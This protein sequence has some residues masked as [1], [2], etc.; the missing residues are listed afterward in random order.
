VSRTLNAPNTNGTV[1]PYYY[2]PFDD[3]L[4]EAVAMHWRLPPRWDGGQIRFYWQESTA[5]AAKTLYFGFGTTAFGDG[6]DQDPHGLAN[7]AAVADG[8]SNDQGH[9]HITPWTAFVDVTNGGLD[10]IITFYIYRDG[11]H[12]S[13]TYAYEIITFYIYRDGDHA[14]DTYAYDA[15]LRGVELEYTTNQATDDE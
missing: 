2:F 14:S 1:L 11:D 3:A 9:L 13:D 12:A 5:E 10:K 15:K 4:Q 7:Y 6:D 8:T